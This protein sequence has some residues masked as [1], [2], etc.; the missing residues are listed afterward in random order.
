M[1]IAFLLTATLLGGTMSTF[2]ASTAEAAP[3]PIV[4]YDL[5]YAE[6]WAGDP[7]RLRDAWDH[8]HAVAALQ[9]IV[10]RENPTLYVRAV[11]HKE[12]DNI[13]LDDWWLEKLR[14]DGAWLH[15]RPVQHVGDF[16]GLIRRYRS[17][18]NGL[19][20]YDESVP[21]TSNVASTVA[22][23]NDFLPVRFDRREGSLYRHLT[24]GLKLPVKA[25]LVQQDGSPLFTGK[26]TIPGTQEDSS[27][28]AKN[29]AY[30][31]AIA[32]FLDTGR[33]N[34][35]AM[36]YYIDA[37]WLKNP[38]ASTFWNHTLTNHD[39][40]IA[41]RSFFFDLSPWDDEPATDDPDQPLGTDLETM[42]RILLAV[43]KINGDKRFVHVGG[44]T[45]WAYKYTDLVG[46]K[47]S[48]VPTEWKTVEIFSAYNAYL[49]ADALSLS[50]FANASFFTHQ[51]LPKYPSERAR[52]EVPAGPVPA[53]HHVSFYVGD[54]D[55]AAWLYQ[56]L[57]ALWE[58]EKR[59][60]V[61]MGWAFNPNLSERF[62][63]AFWHTRATRT[64]NDHFMA[65][66]S[67]AGYVNPSLLEAPRPSGLPSAVGIWERH[68]REWYAKFGLSIT[69]F[70]I[71]GYAP[72]MAQS[73]IDAYARFSPDGTVAQQ[74]SSPLS[75]HDGMPLLRMSDDLPPDPQDAAKLILSRMEGDGP[76]FRIFRAVLKRPSW[77][78]EV[79]EAVREGDPDAEIVDPYTLMA[80]A[81][82]HLTDAPKGNG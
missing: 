72:P 74:L 71:D 75:L 33:C 63:A 40:F 11:R 10:N 34:T 41:K 69:G 26:G 3:A 38:N 16:D 28:S 36:G 51:P 76:S 62:P 50:A 18:I 64:A 58:D 56:M 48:G 80:L 52:V 13:R 23:V 5:T 61:P 4:R 59:G 17:D 60:A 57:P 66:D 78:A 15:A 32:R 12:S 42:K 45:P 54:W 21:A 43:A 25:W 73:V 6:R 55:S 67:G 30:R 35:E 29:D 44:F 2:S 1:K 8:V 49:D 24:E 81:K 47:Y 20:V 31:W 27:G 9:G 7:A 65:G 82:R 68:N 79:A 77:Y 53:K 46:G 14:S 39:Y 19:V 37:A 70:V 22:G